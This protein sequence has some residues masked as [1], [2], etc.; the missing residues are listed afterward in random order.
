MKQIIIKTMLVFIFIVSLYL[1]FDFG[2]AVV[3]VD[4]DFIRPGYIGGAIGFSLIS[5]ASLFGFIYY[6]CNH[7]KVEKSRQ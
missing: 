5:S 6:E 4:N 2:S 1:V 7:K 3:T